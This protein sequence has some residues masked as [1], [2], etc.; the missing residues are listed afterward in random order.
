M[1]HRLIVFLGHGIPATELDPF[2]SVC[3]IDGTK[4]QDRLADG[5]FDRREPKQDAPFLDGQTITLDR[6]AWEFEPE[7]GGPGTLQLSTG[8]RALSLSCWVNWTAFTSDTAERAH[9]RRLALFFAQS[10]GSNRA[11]YAP[12]SNSRISDKAIRYVRRNYNIAQIERVLLAEF[13]PPGEMAK[14]TS[15]PKAPAYVVERF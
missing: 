8:L 6:L 2:P 13:G 14:V 11:I 4:L 12:A 5:G 3:Q 9:V 7:H 10:F 15:G 1:G